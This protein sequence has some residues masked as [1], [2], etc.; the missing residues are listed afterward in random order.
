MGPNEPKEPHTNSHL[1]FFFCAQIDLESQIISMA[2][3]Q[4]QQFQ[5]QSDFGGTQGF[6]VQQTMSFAEFGNTQGD[7]TQVSSTWARIW[8]DRS[9]R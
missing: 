1:D 3:F 9:G 2:S 8:T 6:G 4:T 7:L 5:T